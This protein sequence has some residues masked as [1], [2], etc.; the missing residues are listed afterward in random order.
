MKTGNH[1]TLQTSAGSLSVLQ[2]KHF[3]GGPNIFFLTESLGCIELWRDFPAKLGTM[4]NCNVLVY[5]RLGYGKSGPFNNLQRDTDYLDIEADLLL[6]ILD[7]YSIEKAILFGHSDG[8]TIALIFGAK[9]P[10][11][12]MGIITEGAHIFPEEKGANGIKQAIS[13]YEKTDLKSKLEKYHGNKTHDV[14]WIWAGT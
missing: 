5:D 6:E 9:Y 2:I 13:A 14:F 8:G 7:A 3:P 11:R 1:S 4:T 10:S 12:S